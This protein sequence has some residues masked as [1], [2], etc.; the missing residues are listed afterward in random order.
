MRFELIDGVLEQTATRIVAFKRVSM[1]E[2]YLADHFAGFPVLPGVFMIEAMTQAAR[3][4]VL[5]GG[6]W[7]DALPPVLGEVRAL[8]YAHFV[9]PGW[10]LVVAVDTDPK[11]EFAFRGTAHA[12]ENDVARWPDAPVAASGRFRLRTVRAA[13]AI[14][15]AS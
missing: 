7:A 14:A 8:R 1:A 13:N 10:T 11:A 5:A 9:K 15:S 2:E 4:L 12:V 6:T 3:K